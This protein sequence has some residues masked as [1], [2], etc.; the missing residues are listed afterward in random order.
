MP[1][2][3]GSSLFIFAAILTALSAVGGVCVA[4]V[5]VLWEAYLFVRAGADL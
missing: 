3:V 1:S 5:A 4:V 2:S